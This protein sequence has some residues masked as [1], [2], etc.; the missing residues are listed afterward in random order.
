MIKIGNGITVTRMPRHAN[1]TELNNLGA[2]LAIRPEIFEGALNTIFS[3]QN[4]YS[5]NPFLASVL[6]KG[7]E[8]TISS[9]KWEWKMKGADKKP[10]VVIERA[11]PV[12][13]K[14]AGAGRTTYQLKLDTNWWLPGDVLSPGDAGQKYQSR[15]M[16]PAVAHGNGWIYTM[17]LVS[18]DFNAFVPTKYLEAGSRWI[19]L[20]STYEEGAVQDGSTQFSGAISMEDRL[21]K[22]RKRYSITDYAAEEALVFGLPDANG[23]IQHAWIPYVE[24]IYWKQWY[25]E[26]DTAYFYNRN[27]RSIEGST[28]RAVDSFSG[29]HE[30]I[31]SDGHNEYYSH[32][33]PELFE[34]FLMDIWYS[35]TG[36]GEN[37]H[38]KVFT[39]E[40]GMLQF[41]RAMA[42]LVD[43]KGWAMVGG[44]FNPVQKVN[45]SYHDNAYS[46]GMQFTQYKT[47]NG[48]V[49][50][51]VH[52]PIYDDQS[53]NLE[54]DP[55]TGKPVE[56]M[57]Y[58]FMDFGQ[59]SGSDNI[60][61]I[62]KK[63][64]YKF[65]Y[66]AGLINPYGPV[67]N[68]LI[69]HTGEYYSMHV[70][71]ETGVHIQDP[72]RCGSLVLKRA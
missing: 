12:A 72:T 43:K 19:K 44:S 63:N 10:A 26:L 1:M 45:S 13:N 32:V 57:R 47:A 7:S 42:T 21:G 39:G 17:R 35:R 61:I 15:V 53:I 50:E 65:G 30:K 38:V 23:K 34:E 66:H 48:G 8:R 58:T 16:E 71:K 64:G 24:S 36:P 69:A 56:S 40:Y 3:A 28:G 18:D 62:N 60:Q 49:I 22:F 9:M 2:M 11:E 51:L 31:E 14:K 41:S 68:G 25:N 6:K 46:V 29:I 52:N 5:G 55:I 59:A 54:I 27:A 70:S 67:K 37:R 33:T 4:Y 20:Y